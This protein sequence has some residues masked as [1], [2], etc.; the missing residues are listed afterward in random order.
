MTRIVDLSLGIDEHAPEPFPVEI[1]RITHE[2]G[3]YKIGAK[4]RPPDDST[5]PM[6]PHSFPD[7]LFIS[8]ETVKASVH[9]GTHVDA[10]LHFGPMSEDRPARPINALPLE[11]LYGDG[12]VLDMRHKEPG[13]SITPEDISDALN[14]LPVKV[15]PGDIVLIR[16]GADRYFGKPEYFTSYA[17]M[18]SAA[19]EFLID[20]GVRTIGIDSPGLDRP[21]QMMVDDYF[22][23]GDGTVLWP[24]HM[25]GRRREYIHIERLANLGEIP[26][27]GFRFACFP[28]KINNV[29]ASWARAVAIIE[30]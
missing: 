9:C 7:G 28:V 12:F 24:S 26:P 29:G 11:W 3:P 27:Y 6:G 23:T 10:P 20:I 4:F 15:T 2:E 17:G 30:E 8:H 16:T 5:E 21:T 18:S 13:G 22:S 19:T 14:T 25:L 1:G